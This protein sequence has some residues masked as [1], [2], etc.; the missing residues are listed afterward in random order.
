MRVKRSGALIILLEND[1]FVFHEFL[2]QRTFLA[3]P[4]ALEIIRLLHDWTDPEALPGK[5]TSYTRQSVLRALDEL[6]AV[7]AILVEGSQEAVWDDD[8]SQHWLWG[9]LAAAYHFG[10]RVGDFMTDDEGGQMLREMVKFIPSP[11]LYQTHED[12]SAAIA[13]PMREDFPEPFLTMSRRRTNRAM[14]DEPISLAQIADMFLFSLAITAVIEDPDIVD[15]PLKMTPSGGARNPYEGY[16]CARRVEGLAPGVYHYSAMERSLGIVSEEPPPDFGEL[17]AGQDWASDAAAVIF[18][19]ANFERPMWKYHDGTAYRVT[20]IEAG[21]IAQNMMLV[22]THHGLAANPTGAMAYQR[23]EALL[24]ASGLTRAVL[25][26]LAI[27]LPAP[28]E[29]QIPA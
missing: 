26:A 23:I 25:Y 10:T 9:P 6:I 20:A 1:E 18:L 11:P 2:S 8:F 15:L 21:H 16:L 5:L 27:G 7:G 24:G 4:A 28:M 22:A 29:A 14:R 3:N 13:L 19:V 17:L 12:P